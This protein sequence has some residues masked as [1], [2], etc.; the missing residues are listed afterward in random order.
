MG[1]GEEEGVGV[2]GGGGGGGG[3]RKFTKISFRMVCAP[4]DFLT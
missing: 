4:A 2:K 1:W 3:L